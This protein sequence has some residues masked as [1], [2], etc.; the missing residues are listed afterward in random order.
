MAGE[1]IKVPSAW[2]SILA[3]ASVGA[4][5]I[6]G[7][8]SAIQDSALSANEKLYELIDFELGVTGSPSADGIT[9]DLYRRAKGNTGAG[10]EP[11]VSYTH[12]YAGVFVLKAATGGSYYLYG[13]VDGDPKDTYYLINND[14]GALTLSL[15]ARKRTSGPAA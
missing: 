10:P 12:D 5:G 15:T 3:G 11:T 7:E 4:G 9:V 14:T 1:S 8:S 2:V 6:S 13:F